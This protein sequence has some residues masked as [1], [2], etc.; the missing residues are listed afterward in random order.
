MK[1]AE[2]VPGIIA[3]KA[4]LKH[5]GAGPRLHR[6]HAP[7]LCAGSACN[8]WSSIAPRYA[9]ASGDQACV[10]SQGEELLWQISPEAILL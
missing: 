6:P 10:D 5:A 4:G 2:V 3:S 9:F 1:D 8:A 7:L